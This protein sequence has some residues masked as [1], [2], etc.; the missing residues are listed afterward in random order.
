MAPPGIPAMKLLQ[1]NEWGGRLENQILDLLR[2]EDTDIVCLQ[3][4]VD[5]P[6]DAALSVATHTLQTA[7][8]YPHAFSSPV[9][10]FKLMNKTATFGNAI[11]SRLPFIDTHTIFTNLSYKEDF[12]FDSDDYNIRN[13]QHAIIEIAGQ[14]VNLLNHHGHHVRQH[15]EGDAE[16]MRQMTQIA[17]YVKTLSGPVILAGDFN[18]APHSKSLEVINKLLTNLSVSHKLETTRTFLTHKKEVCDYIF[19]NSEVRVKD[20]RALDDLASDHKALLLDFEV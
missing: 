15:K 4:A 9:F 2:Q 3:E 18:L 17:A 5:A 11:I 6:G 14:P 20:F 7:A 13:L 8:N 16:T 19:V 10:S 1:L 12:D